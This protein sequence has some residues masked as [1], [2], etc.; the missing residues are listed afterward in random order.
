MAGLRSCWWPGKSPASRHGLRLRRRRRRLWLR[1]TTRHWG[2]VHADVVVFALACLSTRGRSWSASGSDERD[3]ALAMPPQDA[4]GI[5]CRC[6]QPPCAWVT[7]CRIRAAS[8]RKVAP[9]RADL[10]RQRGAVAVGA[11]PRTR[12]AGPAGSRT[13]GAGPVGDA[14]RLDARHHPQGGGG[15]VHPGAVAAQGPLKGSRCGH[16]RPVVEGFTPGGRRRRDDCRSSGGC[17]CCLDAGLGSLHGRWLAR[18]GGPLQ[19]TANRPRH[20]SDR[21]LAMQI[22]HGRCGGTVRDVTVV[23]LH[24][25]RNDEPPAG[26]ASIRS[27]SQARIRPW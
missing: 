17:G 16:R 26:V 24:S 20:G 11:P 18:G 10:R 3:A 22:L 25:G 7:V 8:G 15:L 27:V 6:T 5:R 4:R 23:P 9:S 1:R 13:E 12:H 14:G 19:G 21:P 2:E